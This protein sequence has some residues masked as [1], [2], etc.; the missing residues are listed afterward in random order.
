[1]TKERILHDW[2]YQKEMM[3]M[4]CDDDDFKFNC[5]RVLQSIYER[6]VKEFGYKWV[7]DNLKGE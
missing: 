4:F 7:K 2:N 5:L 1:M 6:A 3:K